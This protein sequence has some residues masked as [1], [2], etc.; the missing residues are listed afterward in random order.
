[1]SLFK[2]KNKIILALLVSV[3]LIGCQGNNSSSSSENSSLTP[4]SSLPSSE[5][6]SE[7]SSASSSNSSNSSQ[8]S[9]SSQIPSSSDI[10][11]SSETPSS[12]EPPVSEWIPETDPYAGIDTNSERQAFYLDDYVR[13]RSYEDAQYRTSHGLISGDIKDSNSDVFDIV[14]NPSTRYEALKGYKLHQ[15]TYTY[16]NEG[17]FRSYTI[18]TISGTPK[19]IYYG[20]G[21]VT[22]EDV[23]A[24]LFA[25]CEVPE[26]NKYDKSR[27]QSASIS[28]WWKY[29]RVN[30]SY[31]SAN[32]DQYK[33]EPDVP[34][35][36]FDGQYEGEGIYRYYEMDFGYTEL[37]W[38]LGYSTYNTPYNTGSKITRGAVRFVFTATDTDYNLGAKYIPI[39]HRHVFLTNNHYNDFI[40]YLNYENGW[41]QPFGWMSAGNEYC[42][43][44]SS[45]NYGKGYYD[46]DNPIPPTL[47]P[48]PSI[49][50]L[51]TLRAL[52]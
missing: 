46:F 22:L 9:S 6:S 8:S 39:E 4:S 42:S 25:F 30:N 38:K 24:Y 52:A 3:F 17:N 36:D 1:M 26:N 21:Y 31:F 10:P 45:S 16:D 51:A 18:N 7:T 35:T 43:G 33:Y 27:G 13:A 19:T 41:G 14:H 5:V 37:G 28:K 29:G 32:T 2:N 11:S 44:M 23:A 34:R 50:S 47:Y 15:G 12:S 48:V 20:G 40:E 49:V